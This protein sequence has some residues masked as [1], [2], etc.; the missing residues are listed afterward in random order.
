MGRW[1]QEDFQAVEWGKATICISNTPEVT[2][3]DITTITDL[4]FIERLNSIETSLIKHNVK[5]IN[6]K[7][8]NFVAPENTLPAYA[9]SKKM[10]YEYVECDVQFTSDDVPVLLHNS[11]INATARNADGSAISTTINVGETAYNDL[12]QYDFGIWKSDAYAGTKIPTFEEFIRFCKYS[13]LKPYCEIKGDTMTEARVKLLTDI[14]VKYGMQKNVTWISF[15][16]NALN[17]V[18]NNIPTARLG[19]ISAS[20]TTFVIN[21]HHALKSDSNDVFVSLGISAVTDE[22]VATLISEG[23]ETET[24]IVD[25]FFA[26]KNVN[27]YITG[28]TTNCVDVVGVLASYAETLA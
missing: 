8:Y 3:S 19:I 9:L 26:T 25:K 11:T 1:L 23:I 13:G 16:V 22:N 15:A 12:L 5:G 2:I 17:Y 18:K 20:L 21:G 28:I 24:Y 10:G 6:H 14:V 27:P 7:G 4:F